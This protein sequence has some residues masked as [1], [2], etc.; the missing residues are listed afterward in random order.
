[1]IIMEALYIRFIQLARNHQQRVSITRE[2]QRELGTSDC[3]T[4]TVDIR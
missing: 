2:L 1:M 3:E 4:H